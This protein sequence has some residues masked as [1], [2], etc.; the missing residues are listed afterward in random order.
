MAHIEFSITVRGAGSVTLP[1]DVPGGD[2][3]E[4]DGLT[5][6]EVPFTVSNPLNRQVVVPVLEIAVT[7]SAKDRVSVSLLGDAM[8]IAAGG[9]AE[10]KLIVEPR[11]ALTEGDALVVTVSGSEV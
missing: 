1:V 10:N 7:G 9:T 4:I 5:P 3:V 2:V 6:A 11:E 8:S